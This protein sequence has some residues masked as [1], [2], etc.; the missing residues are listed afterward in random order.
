MTTDPGFDMEKAELQ[1]LAKHGPL[2][3]NVPPERAREVDSTWRLSYYI[4]QG[5][6]VWLPERGYRITARGRKAAGLTP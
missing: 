4:D 6:V 3:W 5:Y 1:Y 2:W